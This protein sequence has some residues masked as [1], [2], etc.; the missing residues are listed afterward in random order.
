MKDLMW[1][2]A[3]SVQ[4]EEVDDDHRKLVELFNMLGHSL[5]D[6]ETIDYIQAVLEELISFT[7]WHFRHEERLMLK[8]GYTGL[9]EHQAEHN[10]LIDSAR[11][12]QQGFVQ[13]GKP[14]TEDDIIFLEHW[15]T[16]HILGADMEMS[17]Y[18]CEVM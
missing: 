2:I 12:L 11:K 13:D 9:A 18:L 14:L 16:G 1:D 17:A 10:E 4:I 5:Q 6:G 15:L 7:V 3:L 8:Y